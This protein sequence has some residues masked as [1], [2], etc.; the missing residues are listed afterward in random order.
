MNK[1]MKAAVAGAAGIALLAGGAGT[2]AVWNSTASI[3]SNATVSSG[4]LSLTANTDGVWKAGTTT[5]TSA[6]LAAYRL[7]PGKTLTYTQTLNIVATGDGLTAALTNSGLTAT[8]T[9]AGVTP[10]MAVTSTSSNVT[11]SG[12]NVTVASASS[13]ATVTVTITV[14]L[15]ESATTGQS[16]STTLNA[17]T[18]TLTQTV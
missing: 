3:G 11:V 4:N 13:A 1:L 7:I 12:N 9:I 15:P 2:F 8:G 6:Q 5:L 14:A 16:S 18:F 17:P 10:T